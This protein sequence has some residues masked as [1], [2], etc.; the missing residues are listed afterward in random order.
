MPGAR[1]KRI[2]LYWASAAVCS[3]Q[4]GLSGSV[5]VPASVEYEGKQYTVTALD[6]FAFYDMSGITS[7][8]LPEGL[9]SMGRYAL[10]K[11]HGLKQLSLPASLKKLENLS[12]FAL[13][14]LQSVSYAGTKEQWTAVDK[15]ALSPGDTWINGVQTTISFTCKGGTLTEVE[16]RGNVP[17]E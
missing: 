7:L 10:L 8:S 13:P 17:E 12:A 6:E 3:F 2:C 15:P 11:L 16:W 5:T 4:N 14:A 9:T 1:S